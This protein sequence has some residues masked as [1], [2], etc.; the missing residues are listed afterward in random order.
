MNLTIRQ[1][2]GNDHGKHHAICSF[3]NRGSFYRSFP[4]RPAL[5]IY[6]HMEFTELFMF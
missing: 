5:D 4:L 1:K 3:K 2:K 6:K